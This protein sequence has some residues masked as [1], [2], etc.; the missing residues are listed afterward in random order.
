M[1]MRRFEF[2]EY[3]NSNIRNVINPIWIIKRCSVE[4]FG[5]RYSSRLDRR[6]SS[7]DGELQVDGTTVVDADS[8]RSF[9]EHLSE[10]TVAAEGEILSSRREDDHI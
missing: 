9:S 2:N 7:L 5:W 8:V 6:P 10:V 1:L 3:V 4:R